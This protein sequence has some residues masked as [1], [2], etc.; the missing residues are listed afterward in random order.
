M[1]R[2]FRGAAA[3]FKGK[4]ERLVDYVATGQRSIPVRTQRASIWNKKRR[5]DHEKHGRRN[6]LFGSP[7]G[8]MKRWVFGDTGGNSCSGLATPF[9]T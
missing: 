7:G 1:A 8:V 3:L 6:G 4:E 5:I 2:C 9:R